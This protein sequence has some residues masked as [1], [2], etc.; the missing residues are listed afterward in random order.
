MSLVEYRA[1]QQQ[2]AGNQWVEIVAPAAELANQIAKTEFVPQEMRGKPDVVAA[3]ILYGAE[4]GIGPM[5]SLAK[6]DIVKGRPAPKAELAR[7]LA[8]A[9]GHEISV[10]ES[11]NTRVTVIGRRAGTDHW[12]TVT[13]TMDDV[14]KAGIVNQVYAK[15][16]RQ[17]LL[18][19]ASAELVRAI[20]PDVL[21]GISRFVEEFDDADTEPTATPTQTATIA[22]TKRQRQ[23]APL[24]PVAELEPPP[25]PDDE[26]EPDPDAITEPQIRK[27]MAIFNE[28][29]IK[30]KDERLKVLSAMAGRDL[31]SSKEL[32]KAEASTIIDKLEQLPVPESS[33]P[34]LPSEEPFE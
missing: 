19:R 30:A 13:W 3:C 32:S 34:P 26:P 7:A 31:A 4:I 21:G 23:R 1:P 6:V 9:A 20:C 15:Y 5:M 2:H 14:K 29:G 17:M 33:E 8:L 16:P 24:P 12:L 11:T 25:L 28:Q 18:A 10:T 22:P 27:L